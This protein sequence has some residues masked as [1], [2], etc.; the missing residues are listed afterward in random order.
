MVQSIIAFAL[1]L[2]TL[3]VGAFLVHVYSLKRQMYLVLPVASSWARSK[4][5]LERSRDVSC[6]PLSEANLP[7]RRATDKGRRHPKGP[8]PATFLATSTGVRLPLL[9]S[10]PHNSVVARA[11]FGWG[12]WHRQAACSFPMAI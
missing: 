4:E 11:R 7:R 3:M 8:S 9:F 2:A 5:V 12:V 10:V 6:P 1:L